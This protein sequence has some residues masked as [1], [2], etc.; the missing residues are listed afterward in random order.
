[1]G[2]WLVADNK[3]SSPVRGQSSNRG[4]SEVVDCVII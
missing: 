3:A 4:V 2:K 1:M